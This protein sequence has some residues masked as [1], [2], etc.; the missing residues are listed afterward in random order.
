MEEKNNESKG[1]SL[2]YVLKA[3]VVCGRLC[4]VF[5]KDVDIQEVSECLSK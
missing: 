3:T 2:P 5:K 1:A 4:N